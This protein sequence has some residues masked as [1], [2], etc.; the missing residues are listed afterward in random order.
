MARS[1]ATRHNP[2]DYAGPCLAVAFV[3][4]QCFDIMTYPLFSYDEA[5]LNDAGWQLVTTGRFRADILSL[6]RGF[7]S[8]YLWQPPGLPL[9]S[10][11]S[12]QLFGFGIWQTRLASILFGGL[13]VW[14]VFAFVRSINPGTIGAWVAALALFFWPD[15]VLTAKESRMDTAAILSLVV[16]THLVVQ[17][18]GPA[19]RGR[20]GTY[21]LAGL[22]ASV[23]TIFHTAALPWTISLA[24]LILA[25]ARDRLISAIFF[26]IGAAVLG[27]AWLAYTLQFLAEFQAQYLSLLLN[28]SGGGGFLDRFA[29]E[30]TRYAVEFHRQPTIYLMALFALGGIIAGRRWSEHRIR[31]LLV[32]T[33]LLLFL[34]ALVAGKNSGFYTL[35]PMTLVFCLVGTGIEACLAESNAGYRRR[36]IA[37]GAAAAC[38]A[39]G[40]NIAAFSV[41]PRLLASWF[42]G[43][44]RDYALQMAPLSSRLKPGDQVW[45]SAVTWIAAVKAGAR[46]DALDWVP[47]TDGTRPDPLRHKF[48]VVDRDVSFADSDSYRKVDGFGSELPFVFGSR[49]SNKPYDFDLWQSNSLQ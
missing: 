23:A 43:Q 41:G 9:A 16:A 14:A 25:F 7:E 28:R 1:M 29:A 11:V 46:L 40:A 5:L 13:G 10:A 22:C 39:F 36:W 2:H 26:G 45:G 47:G 19:E 6:N 33:A 49:L 35:Y 4:L 20:P 48:V 31:A 34:H 18:L 37:V 15:W 42:Q 38:L 32:L 17:S 27:I 24:V 8:H 21:F 3:L 12:Y 44:Q 30:G